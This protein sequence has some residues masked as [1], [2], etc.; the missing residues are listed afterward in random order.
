MKKILLL[1]FV[2]TFVAV[3]CNDD[4]AK[5]SNIEGAWVRANISAFSIKT[6]NAEV[7]D[8][9]AK[10]IDSYNK[11]VKDTYIFSN[12][13]RVMYVD[14]DYTDESMFQVG[15]TTIT[16]SYTNGENVV[17]PTLISD[18]T[19]SLFTDETEY[20]QDWINFLFPDKD[21]EISNVITKYTY[22]KK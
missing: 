7:V 6:N 5:S 12:N 21:I 1:L 2:L 4:T 17:V 11:K 3:S 16:F 9:I 14:S 10:D 19:L 22:V 20:Y 15:D 13:G 18:N 8:F